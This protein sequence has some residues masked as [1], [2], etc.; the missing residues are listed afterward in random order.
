M[1]SLARFVFRHRWPVI[2]VWIA[3]TL[4]GAVLSGKLSS[5]WYQSSAVPGAPAYEAGQRTL[6][7]F[8]AGVRSPDVVV[9]R[10]DVSAL[11]GALR[12]AAAAM[13]GARVG[14]AH[15]SADGRT[16]FGIVYPPGQASFDRLS[17]AEPMR[18]AAARG[19]PAGTT[20][21]V[22]GRDALDEASKVGSAGGANV[23]AEALIGGLGALIV[24]LFL[25]RTLPAVL[26]PLAGRRAPVL[27]TF[28]PPVGAAHLPPRF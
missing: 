13:P 28:H 26:M 20:V 10:G 6:A 15:T 16:A 2:G 17:D 5:R 18:A 8:G 19:L 4:L 14:A 21:A 22:T 9:V 3:L 7:A 12:R 25:F 1:S 27:E 23:L 24:L 11:D